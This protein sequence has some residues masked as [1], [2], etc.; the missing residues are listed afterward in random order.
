MLYNKNEPQKK[1]DPVICPDQVTKC[2]PLKVCCST[3]DGSYGCCPYSNGICC[4]QGH[5]CPNDLTCGSKFGECK[6]KSESWEDIKPIKE[7][8]KGNSSCSNCGEGSVCCQNS[9]SEGLCCP[10]EEGTCCGADGYCCPKNYQC[11]ADQQACQY[12][13]PDSKKEAAKIVEFRIPHFRNVPSVGSESNDNSI[14]CPDTIH[15]CPDAYTCCMMKAPFSN[16]LSYGCC[17][18]KEA[19]CCMDGINW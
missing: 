16:E 8:M 1:D 3:G 19:V 12:I 17:P 7:Q 9:K 14:Q 18:F 11:V 5:C 6:K 2:D 4:S 10:Y 13:D 15:F